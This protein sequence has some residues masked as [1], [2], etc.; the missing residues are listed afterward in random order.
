[1]L[2][3]ALCT[4]SDYEIYFESDLIDLKIHDKSIDFYE[5]ENR[6]G[7]TIYAF[8]WPPNG[9]EKITSHTDVSNTKVIVFPVK[10]DVKSLES[11]LS[12]LGITAE[13]YHQYEF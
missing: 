5:G 6:I 11:M 3:H 10:S 8:A 4:D 13:L 9:N 12:A 2:Y 1:M 7:A